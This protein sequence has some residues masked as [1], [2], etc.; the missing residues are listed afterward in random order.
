LGCYVWQ[1]LRLD[2]RPLLRREPLPFIVQKEAF[3][4]LG[5]RTAAYQVKDLAKA[6]AWYTSVL[7]MQPY[8]DQPFYVGFKVGGFELG[9]VSDP[10]AASARQPAGIAYWGVEDAQSA[11]KRLIEL[12]ATDQESVHDVGDGIFIGAVHD[13]F[14]NTLGVIQNP[15]FTIEAK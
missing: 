5:L 3:M 6:K 4:F 13:P 1:H 9:L 10:K 12:G 15:N 11:Y 14:G 7:D 8:F 2:A